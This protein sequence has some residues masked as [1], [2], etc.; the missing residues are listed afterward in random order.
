MIKDG[1]TSKFRAISKVLFKYSYQ[2]TVPISRLSFYFHN[3]FTALSISVKKICRSTKEWHLITAL[4]WSMVSYVYLETDDVHVTSV[5]LVGC[6]PF[7]WLYA[8]SLCILGKWL[9]SVI[10]RKVP[11]PTPNL[12]FILRV[13]LWRPML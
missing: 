8:R 2:S 7:L 13:C 10:L 1:Y 11:T 4:G 6:C 12:R 5:C 9:M 3:I